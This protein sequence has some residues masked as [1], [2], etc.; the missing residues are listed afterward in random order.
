MTR[1][2]GIKKGSNAPWIV[3]GVV[4]AGIIGVL[5]WKAKS[6]SANVLP[7]GPPAPGPTPTTPVQ[8]AA[9]N[10]AAALQSS[11]Y[12]MADQAIYKAFQTAAG[13]TADGFPGTNTMNAL[14]TALQSFGSQWPFN[15]G[16]TAAQIVV[17]PW[18]TTCSSGSGAACYNGSDAPPLSEW[19]AGSPSGSCP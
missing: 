18:N 9:F 3:G 11:G 6:A 14:A 5:L 17:Y 2:R 12:R 13:L 1:K 16:S 8:L 19:C 15:D 4:A 10:M 7:P